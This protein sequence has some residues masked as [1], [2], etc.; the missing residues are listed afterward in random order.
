MKPFRLAAFAAILIAA[1]WGPAAKAQQRIEVPWGE[2]GRTLVGRNVSAVLADGTV[3]RGRV[4]EV[5][6]DQLRFDANKSSNRSIYPKGELSLASNQL[7]AFSYTQRRGHWRAAGAA[8]GAAGGAAA[9]SPLLIISGN[10]SSESVAPG[11]A[12]FAG[13]GAALGYLIG[14]EADKHEIMVT[15]TRD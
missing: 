3:L 2:L 12:L 14:N 4:L 5:S 1:V 8:I 10:E 15:I 11:Y 13:I 7:T 9:I 6:G